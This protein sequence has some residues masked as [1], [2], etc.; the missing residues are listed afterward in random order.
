MLWG[1]ETKGSHGKNCFFRFPN[2]IFCEYNANELNS[3]EL[4]MSLRG[5][6]KGPGD[7]KKTL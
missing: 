6:E 7:E 2:Q 5:V 4:R 3:L 1:L